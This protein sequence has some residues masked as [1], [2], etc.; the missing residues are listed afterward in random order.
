MSDAPD[1]PVLILYM[2]TTLD[3]KISGDAGDVDWCFTDQD[4][5]FTDFVAS[6]D[7]IL[8]GGR[9]YDQ[10][11]SFGEWPWSDLPV[12]VYSRRDRKAPAPSVQFVKDSPANI[13]ATL[14]PAVKRIWLFGGAELNTECF[15]AGLVD[16]V[17]VAVH[18]V[19][20]GRGI[21]LANDLPKTVQL[22]Y[23]SHQA[24][25]SGLVMTHYRVRKR[26]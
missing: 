7:A 17:V 12:Y 6:I 21:P 15:A 5:G 20:L 14:P 16:E 23:E 18:P 3:G 13:M 9:S 26:D 22:E 4:Y 11:L 2:A 25:D 8:M 10:V 19:I 1:S 24:Y